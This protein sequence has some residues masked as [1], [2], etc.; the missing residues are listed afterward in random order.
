MTELLHCFSYEYKIMLISAVGIGVVLG[1][2]MMLIAN[3]CANRG[4]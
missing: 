2:C 4:W 1:V 3:L